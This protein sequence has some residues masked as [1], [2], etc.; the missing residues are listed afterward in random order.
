MAAPSSFPPPAAAHDAARSSRRQAG[1]LLAAAIA[2]GSVSFTLVQVALRELSPITLATGRVVA[3]ASMF[4]LIV[5]RSPW[6]RRPILRQ[7][8]WRVFVCGFGGSAV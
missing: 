3:S 6:R 5:L 7:D 2:I 8:R 4:T 1:L